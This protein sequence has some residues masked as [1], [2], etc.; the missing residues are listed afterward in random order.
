MAP[1]LSLLDVLAEVPDPRSRHGVRHPLPAILSLAV[2]AMLSGCRGYQAIAQF[3]REHGMPLAIALGFRRGKTPAPSTFC[4]I[5]QVL[6]VTAFEA[7]LTRWIRSRL[8]EGAELLLCLDGKTL[9][10]SK[11][12]ELPGHHL[13]AAYA[14]HC[15]AVLAQLRVDA[16]TNEHKAALQLLGLLP[17]KGCIITG[18]AMFCQRDLCVAVIKQGGD[19][20]FFAKDNQPSLVA[21]IQAGLAF[22]EQSRQT[23]AIFSPTGEV[24]P[25]SAELTA[26]SIDK[27]HGRLEKR[28]IRLT[29]NLTKHSSW[30]GLKQGF[31]LIRE[32]TQKG[33]T[34]VEVAHG[35]TSLSAERADAPRLLEL[36]RGHWE[37]ENGLH[38]RRDVTLGEDA[39]RIRKG[40]AP[41]VMAALRNS[42]LHVL[43]EV[44][45]PS[46]AS[47]IRS[48][49]N[50]LSQ[51]LELLALPPLK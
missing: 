39:S 34:T 27:G 36:T 31:E 10:G 30:K 6:D 51:A 13:V 26:C 8:P 49:G 18:D 33:K 9:R 4:E 3:G 19:Y 5:F 20:L 38:Y 28:T 1:A 46:V 45:A 22:Q 23:A 47:A 2:L 15:Q 40:D 25:L 35:I 17:V 41:Q 11:D 37:I 7:S 42:V 32:R 12:G 44:V 24:P 14:P 50:R 48:M 43:S 29:R 16:K 21:D